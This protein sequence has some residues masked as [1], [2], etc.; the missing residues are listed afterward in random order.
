MEIVRWFKRLL[1]LAPPGVRPGAS[2]GVRP[3]TAAP[4]SRRGVARL[5]A[6]ET[7]ARAQELYARNAQWPQIWS[8][9]N[10][11]GDSV[12]QQ[13]LLELRNAGLQFAPSDGLSKVES[14]CEGLAADPAADV[15]VVLRK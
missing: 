4:P 10:P 3:G 6:A 11:A 5:S 7:R 15:V 8:A 14:A 9:L 1:G 13:L 12:V 2:L